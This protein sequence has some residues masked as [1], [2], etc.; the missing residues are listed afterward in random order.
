MDRN[1]PEMVLHECL[2]VTAGKFAASIEL[3]QKPRPRTNTDDDHQRA[4]FGRNRPHHKLR[5]WCIVMKQ[6]QPSDGRARI[7]HLPAAIRLRAILLP[8]SSTGVGG[9]HR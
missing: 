5:A 8:Q 2:F 3:R 6:A 4:G 9:G 7:K 1:W